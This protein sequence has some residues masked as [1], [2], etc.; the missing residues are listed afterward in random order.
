MLENVDN[1]A[2]KGAKDYYDGQ[3]YLMSVLKQ[4]IEEIEQK[5]FT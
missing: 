3:K 4:K 5:H 1:A 2:F